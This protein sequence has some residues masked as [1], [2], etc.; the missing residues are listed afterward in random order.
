MKMLRAFILA[1]LVLS[2]FVVPAYA[3]GT[4]PWPTRPV[5]F[6]VPFPPGGS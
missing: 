6:L 2:G 1:T 5:R 3:Q 4:G